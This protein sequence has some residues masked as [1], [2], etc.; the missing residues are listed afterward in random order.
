MSRFRSYSSFD[1]TNFPDAPRP[2]R[3][4]E[5]LDPN[6]FVFDQ[7]EGAWVPKQ[8]RSVCR[9]KGRRSVR[10]SKGRRSVRRSKGRSSVRRSKGRSKGRKR[11]TKRIRT[12]PQGGRYYTAMSGRR[13]YV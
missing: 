6:D 5:G 8:R 3:F 10:R 11:W 13:V 2:W 4:I 1:S 12:G 7:D 9:S